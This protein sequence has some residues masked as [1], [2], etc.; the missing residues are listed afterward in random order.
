[1]RRQDKDHQAFQFTQKAPRTILAKQKRHERKLGK[2]NV[3]RLEH[4]EEARVVKIAPQRMIRKNAYAAI[5][6]F[7]KAKEV[8]TS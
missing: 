4:L 8:V 6:N 2:R 3:L 5:V 7:L 1:M